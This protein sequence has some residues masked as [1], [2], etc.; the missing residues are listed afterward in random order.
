[1]TPSGTRVGFLARADNGG[2]GCESWEFVRNFNPDKVLV[3]R[4][5]HGHHPERFNGYNCQHTNGIPTHDDIDRFLKDIDVVFSIET[6]YNWGIIDMARMRGI[7]TVLRVN[8]ELNVLDTYPNHPQPDMVVLPSMWHYDDIR[9]PNKLF[10]PFPVNRKVLPYRE[11]SRIENFYFIAGHNCFE[12]RNGVEVMLAAIPYIQAPVTILSQ[13]PMPYY[14]NTV[15]TDFENYWEIHKGDCLISPRRYAGQSLPM[16][17]ALSLGIPVIMPNVSPQSDL[18]PNEMLVPT[19]GSR[20]IETQGGRIDRY[21]V[22]PRVLAEKVNELYHSDITH[23][24]RFADQYAE[25]ISWE[26]LL[27]KYQSMFDSVR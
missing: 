20:V 3:I 5:E 9:H 10:L 15:N 18:L 4:G 8:F 25:T 19:N 24:S 14:P 26:T 1:M 13:Y 12:D 17:E 21:D 22:D 16:N 11:R 2:L 23:L 27:P 6:F 7:R